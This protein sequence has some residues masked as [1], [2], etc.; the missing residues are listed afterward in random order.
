MN[1][2]TTSTDNPTGL[3]REIA[4]I[5]AVVARGFG[6]P[7]ADLDGPVRTRPLPEIRHVAMTLARDLTGASYP[8]LARAFNKINHG[9]AIHA[10]RTTRGRCETSEEFFARFNRLAA[11]GRREIAID[12]ER[13][14]A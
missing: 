11:L 12:R 3:E 13:R 6:V 7:V 14:V 2:T 10:V 4:L 5:K 9:T 1:T 8:V